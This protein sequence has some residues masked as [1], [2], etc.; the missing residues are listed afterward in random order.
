MLKI[1]VPNPE[2][3]SEMAALKLFNGDGACQLLA[4]DEERG[5]LLL[6]SMQ[7]VTVLADITDDDERTNIAVDVM[8]KIWR[9][10]SR[11]LAACC[12]M[13]NSKLFHS[14]VS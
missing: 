13:W 14:R 1:G 11:S 4:C 10:S 12:Q 9:P 7:S 2:L 3:N 5:S 6:A 8:Q